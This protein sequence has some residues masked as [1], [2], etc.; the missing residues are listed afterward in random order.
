M[1]CLDRR[2]DVDW[3]VQG[4]MFGAGTITKRHG[5][6]QHFLQLPILERSHRLLGL[7]DWTGSTL[8]SEEPGR[9]DVEKVVASN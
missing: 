2:K 7:L 6:S 3:L 1:Y 8:S 9:E 5:T 4:C